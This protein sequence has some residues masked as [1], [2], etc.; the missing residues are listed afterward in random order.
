ME[1][2]SLVYSVMSEMRGVGSDLLRRQ[3]G[4]LD[5][6]F[7]DNGK[8]YLTTCDFLAQVSLMRQIHSL[9]CDIEITGEETADSLSDSLSGFSGTSEDYARITKAISSY[10]YISGH[11]G[12][13][14]GKR[15]YIDPIDGTSV[16]LNHG[17]NWSMTFAYEEMGKI[18]ASVIHQPALD[19]TFY[20]IKGIPN[21]FLHSQKSRISSGDSEFMG[22]WLLYFVHPRKHHGKK[23]VFGID[24]ESL[25]KKIGDYIGSEESIKPWSIDI[26]RPGSGSSSFAYSLMANSGRE[27]GYNAGI[28]LFQERQD[29]IPGGYILESS[30][31]VMELIPVQKTGNIHLS[32]KPIPFSEAQG[33]FRDENIIYHVFTA[34][35]TGVY[36]RMMRLIRE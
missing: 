10:D 19:R 30:G 27:F 18:V 21:M 26:A 35:S 1:L 12:R 4:K 22:E 11:M 34:Q 20:A 7:K 28:A 2:E 23:A 6:V 31:G 29:V 14:S 36:D 32:A 24:G 3:K 17:K 8:D 16:F 5:V 15:V 25:R 33:F 13:N 9:D